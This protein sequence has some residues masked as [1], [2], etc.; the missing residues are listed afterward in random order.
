MRKQLHAKTS[1]NRNGAEIGMNQDTRLE[2]KIIGGRKKYVFISQLEQ[3]NG[4][5]C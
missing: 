2:S 5:L 3:S 4:E 1:C